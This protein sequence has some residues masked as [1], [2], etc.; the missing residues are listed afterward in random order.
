[1]QDNGAELQPIMIMQDSGSDLQHNNCTLHPQRSKDI[2]CSSVGNQSSGNDEEGGYLTILAPIHRKVPE[3]EAE[4][5]ATVLED[6]HIYD[7]DSCFPKEF[8]VRMRAK[9]KNSI[10][11]SASVDKGREF[12]LQS[13]NL[14]KYLSS[15]SSSDADSDADADVNDFSHQ[16]QASLQT[17][18]VRKTSDLIKALD[19]RPDMRDRSSR[20]SM[21]QLQARRHARKMNRK[22]SKSLIVEMS[23]TDAQ[24]EHCIQKKKMEEFEKLLEEHGAPKQNAKQTT[25]GTVSSATKMRRQQFSFHRSESAPLQIPLPLPHPVNSVGTEGRPSPQTAWDRVMQ[26]TAVQS[27][28]GEESSALTTVQEEH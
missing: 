9:Y 7:N 15:D 26:D 19:V 27:I 3:K 28:P 24:S 14:P 2:A 8:L 4:S 16:Q 25:E 22:K 18:R 23:S 6:D 21:Q 1:M 11:T 17:S 10:N 12:L 13:I 5:D 20:L